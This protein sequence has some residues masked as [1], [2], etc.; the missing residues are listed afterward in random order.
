MMAE[1]SAARFD[2]RAR[3]TISVPSCSRA[4]DEML[5]SRELNDGVEPIELELEH[6]LADCGRSIVATARVVILVRAGRAPTCWRFLDQSRREHA[7]NR[8][9]ECARAR[10]DL[11]LSRRLDLLSDRVA[12]PLPVAQREQDV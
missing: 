10:A 5:L 4:A 7:L 3:K 6:T 11:P 9:I 1:K 12:V 2:T 8:P